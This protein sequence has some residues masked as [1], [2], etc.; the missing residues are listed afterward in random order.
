M[1]STRLLP[2][3]GTTKTRSRPGC[4]PTGISSS[5]CFVRISVRIPLYWNR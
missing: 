2:S 3:S 5:A 4:Q 1:M